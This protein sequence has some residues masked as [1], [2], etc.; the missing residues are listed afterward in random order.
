[1]KGISINKIENTSPSHDFSKKK[2]RLDSS[3][4]NKVIFLKVF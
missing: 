1:M 4:V 2:I 3:G